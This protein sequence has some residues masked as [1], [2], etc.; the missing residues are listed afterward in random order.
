MADWILYGTEGC[1]LCEEAEALLQQAGLVFDAHDIIDD[2]STQ[3]RYGLRIPV[4]KHTGSEREL[5]WPFDN[6][7]LHDF[8]ARTV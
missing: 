2:E 3:Q 6:A 4:L 7:R 8:I 5:D 1:H